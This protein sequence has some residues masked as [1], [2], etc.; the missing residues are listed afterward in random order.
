MPT[1]ILRPITKDYAGTLRQDGS[2]RILRRECWGATTTDGE[3]GFLRVEETGTPW[4]VIHHP[5]TDHHETA[6]CWFGTLKSAREAVE[7]GIDKWLPSVQ[8]AA[9]ERGEHA[10]DSPYGCRTCDE[11]RWG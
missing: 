5:S 6:T 7:R 2:G 8:L 11:R 10:T 9:H 4:L 1:M 3:W